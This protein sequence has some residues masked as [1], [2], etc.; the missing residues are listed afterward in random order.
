MECEEI[1]KNSVS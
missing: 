1:S